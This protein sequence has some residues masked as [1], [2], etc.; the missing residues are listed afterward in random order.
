MADETTIL[1]RAICGG[2]N[3]VRLGEAQ[4]K[5]VLRNGVEQVTI[6]ARISP[7]QIRAT[8]IG[9]AGAARTEVAAKISAI[10]YDLS[11]ANVE[12]VGDAAIALDA[13][14]GRGPGVIAISG[15]GSIVY[16]RE[17]SGRVARAGGW[18]FAISDEGSGHWIGQRAISAVSSAHD[19]ERHTLLTNLVF[20][21]WKIHSLDEFVQHSNATPS[22]DFPESSR[23][24]FAPQV[25]E[26]S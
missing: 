21:N 9:A 5:D 18:G 12:V 2:S 24:Y 26:T 6:A 14:F 1:A 20:K 22:P 11:L 15:T 13:A 19:E 10:L 7:S 8:C 17:A 4:A 3:I 23:S 25:R 16:G